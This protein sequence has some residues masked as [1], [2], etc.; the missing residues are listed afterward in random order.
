MHNMHNMHSK[1][2]MVDEQ[3]FLHITISKYITLDKYYDV[4]LISYL[5]HLM[6]KVDILFHI[7]NLMN[8]G[9]AYRLVKS[10]SFLE[11]YLDIII[12]FESLIENLSNV[13]I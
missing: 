7:L 3:L 4:I 10:R 6:L 5:L 12:T 9:R 1:Y 11:F 13:K 8:S 2:H